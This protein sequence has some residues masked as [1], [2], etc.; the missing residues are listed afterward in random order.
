MNS[1]EGVAGIRKKL[2]KAKKRVI[3]RKIYSIRR[4]IRRLSGNTRLGQ[5]LRGVGCVRYRRHGMLDFVKE[6]QAGPENPR[7]GDTSLKGA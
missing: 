4:G 5:D 2:T 7:S 6:E 1:A 3:V